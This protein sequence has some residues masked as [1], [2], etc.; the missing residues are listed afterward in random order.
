M[1]GQSP[2]TLIN[3]FVHRLLCETKI[4]RSLITQQEFSGNDSFPAFEY[5][6]SY[7][8]QMVSSF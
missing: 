6:L 2:I 1:Y 5:L 7:K 8:V 3:D 4:P